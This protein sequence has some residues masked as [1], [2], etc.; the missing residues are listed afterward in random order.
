MIDQRR[1][2]A[3]R[4]HGALVRRDQ[5]A[6]R[7]AAGVGEEL[8]GVRRHL[9][10]RL[11]KLVGGVLEGRAPDDRAAPGAGRGGQYPG[12]PLL[13]IPQPAELARSRSLSEARIAWSLAIF[14][15]PLS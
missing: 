7:G 9:D 13:R 5:R 1:Q 4:H 10:A 12:L 6:G 8:G 15:L 3:H 14:G 11:A 2:V